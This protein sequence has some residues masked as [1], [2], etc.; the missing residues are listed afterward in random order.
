MTE[1]IM[2]WNTYRAVQPDIGAQKPLQT[3]RAVDEV[4][5]K[6][7]EAE[8]TNLLRRG[9]G[10]WESAGVRRL[11]PRI[12]PSLP[13]DRLGSIDTESVQ[14]LV[15]LLTL[16]NDR[17][18]LG[19]TKASLHG[20]DICPVG[21]SDAKHGRFEYLHPEAVLI[22]AKPLHDLGT[23]GINAPEQLELL[24]SDTVE[25]LQPTPQ[26]IRI[27]LIRKFGFADSPGVD[28]VDLMPALAALLDI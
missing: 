21:H 20:I 12:Y 22:L 16:R 17:A 14:E 28:L 11:E 1:E 10:R 2:T 9:R 25:L 5:S 13:A 6:A 7:V 24:M 15:V 26:P 3:F 23:V 8:C 27:R 4:D 18:Q 19:A